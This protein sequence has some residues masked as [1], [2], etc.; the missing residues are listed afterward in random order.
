MYDLVHK[1]IFRKMTSTACQDWGY[2]YKNQYK[3]NQGKQTIAF[4]LVPVCTN[5]METVC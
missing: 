4:Y 2:V 5:H 1:I 3:K